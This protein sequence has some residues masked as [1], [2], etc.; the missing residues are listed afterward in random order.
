MALSQ[1]TA[2]VLERNVGMAVSPL[3]GPVR[4]NLREE[5]SVV[6]TLN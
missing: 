2:V 1:M 6:H 3:G 4:D 5:R